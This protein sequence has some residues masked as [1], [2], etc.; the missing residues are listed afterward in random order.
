[1]VRDEWFNRFFEKL[2]FAHE[3]WYLL[4][5]LLK[6]TMQQ[7][8]PDDGSHMLSRALPFDRL[9]ELNKLGFGRESHYTTTSSV[10]ETIKQRINFHSLPNVESKYPEYILVAIDIPER[11]LL[12][13]VTQTFYTIDDVDFGY[14]IIKQCIFVERCPVQKERQLVLY[15]KTVIQ[16]P[17]FEPVQEPYIEENSEDEDPVELDLEDKKELT[18]RLH[19]EVV[20]IQFNRPKT[21]RKENLLENTRKNIAKIE[22][23]KQNQPTIISTDEKEGNNRKTI[24]FWVLV[25]SITLIVL[26]LFTICLFLG[27]FLFKRPKSNE[28]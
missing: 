28:D 13:L 2:P 1:M 18:D 19:T 17:T 11:L 7:I 4:G 27:H 22:K 15:K 16:P 14:H 24:A 21:A 8:L 6:Q 10:E 20:P 23:E 9:I 25:I 3:A 26:L 12:P 5:G